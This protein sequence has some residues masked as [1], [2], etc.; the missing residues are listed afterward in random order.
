[1][2]QPAQGV[3]KVGCDALEPGE[4]ALIPH[5]LD[6]LDEPPGCQHR[7]AA[8]LGRRHAAPDVVG[9]RHLKMG[10]QLFTEFIV[11]MAILV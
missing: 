11:Q 7:L 2:S 1:V 5:R 10:L 4:T 8:R 6:C 9:R 3:A